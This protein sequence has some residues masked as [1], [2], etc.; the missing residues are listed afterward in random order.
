MGLNK[1]ASLM[2]ASLVVGLIV[3]AC[4]GGDEPAATAT[5]AP[6]TTRTPGPTAV[7]TATTALPAIVPPVATSSI[8]D[9]ALDPAPYELE[10]VKYGGSFKLVWGF[11]NGFLDPKYI[12]QINDMWPAGEK[13][14][15][16]MPNEKDVYS[17]LEPII[18]EGWK[19]SADLKTYTITLKKGVKWQNIAPVNGRE[20]V[21]DDAVFNINRYADKDSIRLPFYS[22]I[23]STRAVDKY[24]VEIKIKEPT[25]WL[26]NDIFGGTDWMI[27]PEVI[28]EAGGSRAGTKFIGTGPYILKDYKFRQG[29]TFTRNPD[30]W[31][32]DARGRVLPYTDSVEWIFILDQATIVAGF[33]TGQ[34]DN[35]PSLTSQGVAGLEAIGKSVP[36]MRLHASGLSAFVGLGFNTK[37]APWNDV[38]VRRAMNM[39]IDKDKFASVLTSST[40]LYYS[41]PLT[42][43]DVSDKP[44]NV[45]DLGPYFKYNP[46]EAK[47][48]LIEAGFADG[49]MKIASPMEYAANASFTIY[50][51][52]T[53]EQLKQGGIQLDL[54]QI[55]TSEYFTK[56]YLQKHEDISLN[57]TN[58]GDY[59]L[60]WYAQ[61]KYKIGATQNTSFISDPAIQQA[62][63]D[64]K[65]TTD[66]VKLKALAKTL[67][68]YDT[69]GSLNIWIINEKGFGATSPHVRNYVNRAA[70]GFAGLTFMPWLSDAPRTSP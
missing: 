46:T 57:F 28:A 25:A 59:S 36:G 15:G 40:K 13:L 69:Q 66:P 45:D 65:A 6:L 26:M 20:F 67:W 68:D 1:F 9:T 12:I 48:L 21:A 10:N 32:K 56:W 54:A 55:S 58:T 63:T 64:I 5:S 22:Q 27:P 31:H 17:H 41:T 49:K 70:S 50:A 62:V 18:A 44:F 43:T 4:G 29:M 24:T 3:A 47:K 53:Q 30:Y 14:V 8:L 34:L 60:N 39:L 16:W 51:Q 2:F 42:W 52:I 35:G 33:R 19:T 11:S 7:I 38:R 23:E 37:K 61:N